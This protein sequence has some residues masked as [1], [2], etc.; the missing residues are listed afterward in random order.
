MKIRILS[1]FFIYGSFKLCIFTFNNLVL[2][3]LIGFIFF[4]HVTHLISLICKLLIQIEKKSITI[5]LGKSTKGLHRKFM[6]IV[7]L[8]NEFKIQ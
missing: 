1:L 2:M 5:Q 3:F 6:E 8:T 7:Q 4:Q